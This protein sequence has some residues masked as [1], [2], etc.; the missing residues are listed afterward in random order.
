M[1]ASRPAGF[2]T[3]RFTLYRFCAPAPVGTWTGNGEPLPCRF[4]RAED[5]IVSVAAALPD[6]VMT[7]SLP[8]R[9][10]PV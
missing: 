9:R 10:M 1:N 4:C 2:C 6:V 3:G 8:L 7:P 5:R